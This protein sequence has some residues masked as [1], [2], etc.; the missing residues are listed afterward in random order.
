MCYLLHLNRKMATTNNFICLLSLDFA[1]INPS[2]K[3]QVQGGTLFAFARFGKLFHDNCIK[4]Y[5]VRRNQRTSRPDQARPQRLCDWFPYSSTYEPPSLSWATGGNHVY[6]SSLPFRSLQWRVRSGHLPPSWDRSLLFGAW[7]DK[8]WTSDKC[9][10]VQGN[11]TSAPGSFIP[12]LYARAQ[13]PRHYPTRRN[14]E[15]EIFNTGITGTWSYGTGWSSRSKA[16]STWEHLGSQRVRNC[17]L[18]LKVLGPL[19]V[20]SFRANRLTA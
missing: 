13:V 3:V 12:Y 15:I 19:S 6:L 4:I 9:V 7:K 17:L 2:A 18:R 14:Q 10:S 5:K 8:D 20:T 16:L 11:L 1:N